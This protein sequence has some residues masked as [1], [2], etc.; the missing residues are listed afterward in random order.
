MSNINV[1]LLLTSHNILLLLSYIYNKSYRL[2]I[3]LAC[4]MYGLRVLTGNRYETEYC[5][6]LLH[7]FFITYFLKASAKLKLR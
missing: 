1:F 5:Y 4:T 3:I 6:H 2:N 7:K